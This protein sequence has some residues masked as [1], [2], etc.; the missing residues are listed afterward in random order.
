MYDDLYEYE[1]KIDLEDGSIL[2]T[3]KERRSTINNIEVKIDEEAAKNIV[4]AQVPEGDILKISL[5]YE[6]NI[7][8]YDIKATD[9]AYEYE[10]EVNANDGTIITQEKEMLDL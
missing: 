2:E 1:F 9:G 3:G 6:D 4:L 8:T 5:E 7:P 10:F